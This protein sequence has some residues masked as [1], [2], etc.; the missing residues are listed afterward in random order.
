[1][2]ESRSV[3]IEQVVKDWAWRQFEKRANRKERRLL[4]KERRA[5]E[6]N[7]TG[8]AYVGIKIDWSE[9]SFVDN[10][11]WSSLVKTDKNENQGQGRDEGTPNVSLLFQTKFTNNTQ[12]PQEYSMRT[13]KVTTST[14]STEIETCYTRGFEMG[15]TLKSPCEVFEANAGYKRE[16]SLTNVHGQTFEEELYWGVDS[17]IR[18]KAKHEAEASLIVDERKQKGD[19][20]VNSE[21]WGMVYA[22]F[23][24]TRENN[25]VIMATGHDIAEIM[26][27][28]LEKQRRKGQPMEFVEVKAE[29]EGGE[30]KVY[31]QTKGRCSFRYG[32]RQE[33]KVNQ[34]QIQG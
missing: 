23:Y 2:P 15:I 22:K 19:F 28:Y 9:V 7:T 1:M 20:V 24:N 13:E 11:D 32:I 29:K 12:E 33:I 31:I 17:L 16:F 14:A 30:K 18:V 8:G 26:V 34:K 4:A 25:Q 27:G 3:N 10:T 21:I 5:S 6:G